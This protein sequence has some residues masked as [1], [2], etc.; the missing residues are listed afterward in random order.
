M[1]LQG[2]LDLRNIHERAA[3]LYLPRLKR[4]NLAQQI[5]L[6]RTIPI[7]QKPSQ[8]CWILLS[9][10]VGLWT[11][12]P[13]SNLPMKSWRNGEGSLSHMISYL[14]FFSIAHYTPQPQRVLKTWTSSLKLT[15]CFKAE[16]LPLLRCRRCSIHLARDGDCNSCGR[17][18]NLCSNESC[19]IW[20]IF[21][22]L[23]GGVNLKR[24]R[25]SPRGPK[26]PTTKKK[27]DPKHPQYLLQ[28]SL[29]NNSTQ[30]HLNR[31]SFRHTAWI[32]QKVSWGL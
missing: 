12:K 22:Q 1:R 3:I 13:S 31:G 6:V 21:A 17:L 11:R 7:R 27:S 18:A 25:K 10:F 9:L 32:S 26:K 5:L 15:Y 14:Y 16:L 4:S 30:V 2:S 19:W 28:D 20:S 8:P 29:R 24:F 23:C